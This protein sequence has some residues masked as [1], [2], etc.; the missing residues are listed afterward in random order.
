MR[1]GDQY[2]IRESSP[3]EWFVSCSQSDIFV[4]YL[5]IFSVVKILYS[6]M[7]KITFV[8]GNNFIILDS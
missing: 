4:K 8:E 3:F 7:I 2:V 1:F 6:K 5:K